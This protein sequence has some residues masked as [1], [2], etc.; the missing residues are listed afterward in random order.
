MSMCQLTNIFIH[1]GSYCSSYCLPWIHSKE[2]IIISISLSQIYIW[3]GPHTSANALLQT[4]KNCDILQLQSTFKYLKGLV[5]NL[6][7][8]HTLIQVQKW[9]PTWLME[10]N[11]NSSSNSSTTLALNFCGIYEVVNFNLTLTAHGTFYQCSRST[12]CFAIA[13]E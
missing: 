2:C 9:S 4:M 11:N 12:I 8:F 6:F 7:S 5:G 13:A 1:W 3:F 10:K